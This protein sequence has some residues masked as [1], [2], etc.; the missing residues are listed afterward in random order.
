M[1]P[2]AVTTKR[3][4]LAAQL[5]IVIGKLENRYRLKTQLERS[6]LP[7]TSGPVVSLLSIF[8]LIPKNKY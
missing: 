2:T 3:Q 6:L 7:Q 1:F 8:L 4:Q 5:L